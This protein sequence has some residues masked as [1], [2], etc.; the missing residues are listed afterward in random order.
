[1][2]LSLAATFI[3]AGLVVLVLSSAWIG[4]LFICLGLVFFV[5]GPVRG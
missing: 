5:A 3:I 1:M 4:L 2:N